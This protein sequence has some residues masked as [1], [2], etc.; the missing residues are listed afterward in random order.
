MERLPLE[1]IPEIG[2]PLCP[3]AKYMDLRERAEA[4]CN[5]ADYLSNEDF[6]FDLVL[7][8]EDEAIAAK[9]AFSYASNATVTS[10]EVTHKRAAELRP[11]SLV[12]VSEILTE[13]GQQVVQNAVEIRNLVTN[14][15]LLESE[16]PDPRVRLKAIELLG[17]V[18]DVG[19]FVEKSE[20]VVT[21]QTS[22]QL[23]DQ[24]RSK[25]SKLVR[26]EEEITE[27][28]FS[29]D[30]MQNDETVIEDA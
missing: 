21:V 10:K 3:E 24:L 12:L 18:S 30:S 23:K 9:L 26:S 6:G 8:S 25:L 7:T 17:K 29:I 27:A 5:T 22:D 15:L 14:K 11:A 20:R 2:V 1:V 28:E 16:H 19:L 4:V 13:F